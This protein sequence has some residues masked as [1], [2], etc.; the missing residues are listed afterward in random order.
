MRL[1]LLHARLWLGVA[2]SSF[3]PPRLND[4]SMLHS[5]PEDWWFRPL[6]RWSLPLLCRP[7]QVVPE[8]DARALHLS[9]PFQFSA[10]V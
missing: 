1:I 4:S 5:G 2:D 10:H 9:L 6:R 7:V 8:A 3:P